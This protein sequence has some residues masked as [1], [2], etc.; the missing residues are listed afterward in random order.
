MARNP[1]MIQR[2][3]SVPAYIQLAEHLKSRIRM[4]HFKPGARMQGEQEL[5]KDTGLSRITVRAA[6]KLLERD[7]W[8]IR[9]QGIGTFAGACDQP[10]IIHCQYYT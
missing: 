3:T 10:R 8:A 5:I 2:R 7:G 1:T 4:G 6:L 9:R